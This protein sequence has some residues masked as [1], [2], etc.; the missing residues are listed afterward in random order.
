MEEYK[1]IS[2]IMEHLTRLRYASNSWPKNF[3][4]AY[5]L[6]KENFK[7]AVSFFN[8][9]AKY[10]PSDGDVF[11]SESAQ[12][13]IDRFQFSFHGINVLIIKNLRQ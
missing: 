3:M 10:D 11:I 8:D 6:G 7:D 13:E 4:A 1:T 12:E 5:S 2:D 9:R